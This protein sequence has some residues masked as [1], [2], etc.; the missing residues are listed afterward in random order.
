MDTVFYV[1]NWPYYER[2]GLARLQN[3]RWVPM[4]I[5][6]D[7]GDWMKLTRRP[8]GRDIH[9]VWCALVSAAAKSPVRGLALYGEASPE[10]HTIETLAAW[11]H[12]PAKVFTKAM[13]YLVDEL[14]WIGVAETPCAVALSEAVYG[15]K[16]YTP[17]DIN[18]DSIRIQSGFDPDSIRIQTGFDA[19]THSNSNKYRYRNRNNSPRRGEEKRRTRPT[20]GAG[21]GAH[22][23]W[24]DHPALMDTLLARV[25]ADG[26]AAA[27]RAAMAG[28]SAK[29]VLATVLDIE[30]ARVRPEN[31]PGL[32]CKR[33][34]RHFTPS[35]AHLDAAA[36]ELRKRTL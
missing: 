28:H 11:S 23:D 10:P 22:P 35:D 3:V 7:G 36:V 26:D 8:D 9:A 2:D 6:M 31:P 18:P 20:N 21:G 29:H 15:G 34:Q 13:P 30:R 27:L 1:T 25:G 4:K 17:S 32:L 24:S 16:V 33:L 5:D 12:W 14:G 19:A